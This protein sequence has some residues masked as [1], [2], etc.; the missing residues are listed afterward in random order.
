MHGKNALRRILRKASVFLTVVVSL[1]TISATPAH[2][3]G[4]YYRNYY[5]FGS[6]PNILNEALD[7]AGNTGADDSVLRHSLTSNTN[8]LWIRPYICVYLYYTVNPTVTKCAG[9]GA[10]MQYNGG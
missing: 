6:S 4:F 2:A 9:D 1:V 5:F 10:W 3:A 7:T 8:A